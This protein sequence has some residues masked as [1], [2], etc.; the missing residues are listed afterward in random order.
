[1]ALVGRT[2]CSGVP[3]GPGPLAGSSRSSKPIRP[4]SKR[5]QR[6]RRLQT[7]GSAP[8]KAVVTFAYPIQLVIE[9]CQTTIYLEASRGWTLPGGIVPRSSHRTLLNQS[10]AAPWPCDLELPIRGKQGRRRALECSQ[11]P[12]HRQGGEVRGGHGLCDVGGHPF[13]THLFAAV[14]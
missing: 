1:M 11:M 7:R 12:I 2:L 4:I 9:Y 14:A 5:G 13:Y 10:D 8:A 3:S 6:G